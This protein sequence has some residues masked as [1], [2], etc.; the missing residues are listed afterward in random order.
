MATPLFYQIHSN[1]SDS[2]ASGITTAITTGAVATFT[3]GPNKIFRI[4]ATTPVNV[5]FGDSNIT[6]A[7]AQDVY[8]PA[9]YVEFFDMG[10]N[11]TT[12]A[13]FAAAASSVNVS[14]VSR[15]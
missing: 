8:I 1:S 2:V 15:T 12:I 3:I 10:T 5:R 7:T 13:V 4:V 11:L 14:I 9:N 6:T